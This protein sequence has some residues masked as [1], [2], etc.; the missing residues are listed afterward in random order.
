MK[1]RELYKL[2]EERIKPTGELVGIAVIRTDNNYGLQG[3]VLPDGQIDMR[4]RPFAIP[5]YIHKECMQMFKKESE[6]TSKKVKN[7]QK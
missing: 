6:K 2:L 4:Y 1:K 3:Y 5:N 7:L